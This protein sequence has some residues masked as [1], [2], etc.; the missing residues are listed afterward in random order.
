MPFGKGEP[1]DTDVRL[2]FYV[3]GPGVRPNVTLSHPTNLLDIT[4]T[5]VD[6]AGATDFLP[7][8]L[9][10]LSFAKEIVRSAGDP[11]PDADSWRQFAFS[12]FFANNNTWRLVRVANSTHKFSYVHWCTNESE[13]FNMQADPWQSSNIY[14]TPGFAAAVVEE[15]A[16]R[17]AWLGSCS[18]NSCHDP[19]PVKSVLQNCYRTLQP[20]QVYSGSFN[21][22]E[23]A[24]TKIVHGWAV[25][26]SLD[27]TSP[28]GKP[29]G[30]DP[31][32]VR[33][34]ASAHPLPGL[35]DFV[36]NVSRPDIM[37]NS[38]LPIPNPN[39]GFSE[40][41]PTAVL[42]QKHVS[43]MAFIV[44]KGQSLHP[45]S[46]ERPVCLCSGSVCPCD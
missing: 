17:A 3:R 45:L 34:L 4:A 43:L 7:F 27:G 13:V 30:F 25:D 40:V 39:H 36:A 2:P 24:G 29:A 28:Q 19:Q 31:A 35:P 18:G 6:L 38:G 22:V 26:F 20:Q 11:A 32:T 10:G 12:E 8:E 1:Y 5:I 21:V 42:Q 37:W 33:I 41:L 46:N 44:G 9:D 23:A 15:F 14:G 16:G